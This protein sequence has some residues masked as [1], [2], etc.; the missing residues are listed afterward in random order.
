MIE[1]TL[2]EHNI[3]L[4]DCRGQ[5]YDNGDNMAGKVKGVQ[6]HIKEKNPTATFSPCASHTLNLVGVHAAQASPEINI[7]FG[8]VN[9]L[10]KLFSGSPQR[11]EVSMKVLHCSLH[12]LSDTRWSA[13]IEA[14]RPL[15]KHLPDVLKSLEMLIT[16]GN[17][18]SEAKA[19]AH[20]LKTYFESFEAVVLLTFWVKVLGCIE[21]RN[22]ASQSSSLSLEIQVASVKELENEMACVNAS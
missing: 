7:F 16:Q 15:A 18:T 17:L 6:A 10:Y 1:E 20:G 5:C 2:H 13:R 19:Q 9:E 21:D 12:K 3:D 4:G 22:L 14:V 8:Y 11:W